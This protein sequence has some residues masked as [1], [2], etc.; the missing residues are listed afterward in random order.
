MLLVCI[1]KRCVCSL[2]IDECKNGNHTCK[3]NAVCVNALG[4]Y[5]CFCAVGYTG[6]NSLDGKQ[7]CSGMLVES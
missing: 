4:S 3:E 7:R 6:W 2:D 5:V 1:G